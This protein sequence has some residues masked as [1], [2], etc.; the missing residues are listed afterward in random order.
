MH[1]AD[2]GE[3]VIGCPGRRCVW[4]SLCWTMPK[5]RRLN[6]LL[7]DSQEFRLPPFQLS[8]ARGPY[9]QDKDVVIHFKFRTC[10]EPRQGG[11]SAGMAP[12][13]TC[14]RI[15]CR[16]GPMIGRA[17]GGITPSNGSKMGFFR[18]SPPP[19]G[20]GPIHLTEYGR[21]CGHA[22]EARRE[23]RVSL[24]MALSCADGSPACFYRECRSN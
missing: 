11:S 14:R 19:L 9:W 17:A 2:Y 20:A 10:D 22:P 18:R 15:S 16:P 21:V 3:D 7:Q 4:V 8:R 5:I 13:M 6:L 23:N 24:N 12:R 1:E